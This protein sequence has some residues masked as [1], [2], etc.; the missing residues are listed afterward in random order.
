VVNSGMII[1]GTIVAYTFGAAVG[2]GGSGSNTVINS[3][4]ISGNLRLYGT[5][6]VT[7]SGSITGAVIAHAGGTLTNSGLITGSGSALIV[8]NTGT[9]SGGGVLLYAGGTLT[10]S[11]TISG[12]SGLSGGRLIVNYATII[13]TSGVGVALSGNS[14]LVNSG[15]ITG[16]AGTAVSFG[17]GTELLVIK[18]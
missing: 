11:G 10:N 12:A 17:T 18:P 15:S 13:G 8:N 6:R 7:N 3:G 14:T 2:L 9:I 5:S 4:S 16:Y 1:G